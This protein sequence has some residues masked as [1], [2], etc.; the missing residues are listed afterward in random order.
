MNGKLASE[1]LR[2]D[3]FSSTNR[4]ASFAGTDQA[5]VEA[6]YLVALCRRPSPAERD[7]FVAQLAAADRSKQKD[8]RAHVVED[9]FWSL[10]N[11]PEFAWNH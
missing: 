1:A 4:V 5:C 2:A 3:A 11:S 8:A 10:F 7:Y 9:L 6:S